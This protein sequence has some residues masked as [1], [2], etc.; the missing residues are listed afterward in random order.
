MDK[1]IAPRPSEPAPARRR[2]PNRRPSITQTI[3]VGGQAFVA[4]IG[5]APEDGSPREVFLD[6]ATTGSD[7]AAI[8]DDAS[9]VLSVA[10]QFGIPPAAL[11]RSVGRLPIVPL[12]PPYLSQPSNDGRKAPASIIGAALDLLQ[13]EV[14]AA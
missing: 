14:E 6:G 5:F 11:A 12:A 2:L 7:L 4:T 8:L 9:V 1:Q 3:E 10:L 13:A